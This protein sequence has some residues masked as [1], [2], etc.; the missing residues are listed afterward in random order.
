MNQWLKILSIDGGGARGLI[1]VRLLEEI[2]KQCQ[3]LSG[4]EQRIHELFDVIA[5][6]STGG[7]VSL[8][9]T[10]PKPLTCAEVKHLYSEHAKDFFFATVWH[11]LKTIGGWL[12]PKYPTSSA[13]HAL[14]DVLGTD[15]ELKDAV[16]E[17]VIP[18]YDITKKHCPDPSRHPGPR[19]FSR[20]DANNDP[21]QNFRMWEVALAAT[22]A[23]TYFPCVPIA[24][25]DVQLHP[26]DGAV[27]LNN[28]AG[29]G[30]SHAMRIKYPAAYAK[31]VRNEE[32]DNAVSRPEGI[33]VLSL[34]TGWHERAIVVQ[35]AAHW[36]KLRWASPL[37]DVMIEA[38]AEAADMILRPIPGIKFVRLQPILKENVK[39][40]DVS[41]R[42]QTTM[43]QACDRCLADKEADIK[44][45]CDKICGKQ[46]AP[47]ARST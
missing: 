24:N 42:A 31:L 16:G 17:V 4:K 1:P 14:Q 15:T 8:M 6:T 5:G 35:R 47:A 18:I 13:K 33:L 40:D 20:T 37:F 25:K 10:K 9:L 28:P 27:Y 11:R 38:Q 21:Q 32:L 43:L 36:G 30:I 19:T 46:S 26:I 22:S 45:V 12:G 41:P 3:C 39:L 44:F 34:G 23:P 29:A 7:V 2:E